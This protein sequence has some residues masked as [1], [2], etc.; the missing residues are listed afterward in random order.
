MGDL[1][2][3]IFPSE[4]LATTPKITDIVRPNTKSSPLE[5]S[6]GILVNGKKNI[7]NKTI[8]KNKEMN[9]ILSI[10]FDHIII[11]LNNNL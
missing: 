5:T 6:T 4:N 7:G 2:K 9:E 8:T 10:I 11:Y 3:L 1:E